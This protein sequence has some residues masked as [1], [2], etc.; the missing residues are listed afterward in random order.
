[1]DPHHRQSTL[2]WGET[3]SI[4]NCISCQNET[5]TIY[6]F[7]KQSCQKQR[8]IGVGA[9]MHT[10]RQTRDE[11]VQNITYGDWVMFQSPEPNVQPFWIGS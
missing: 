3:C 5:T 1:M 7:G 8:G 2:T 4:G 11:M 10:I 9:T 6:D